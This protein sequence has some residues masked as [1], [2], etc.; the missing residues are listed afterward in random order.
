MKR[1]LV[2]TLLNAREET[3][4]EKGLLLDD[5]HFG[6]GDGDG[7]DR[8]R[9]GASVF[10]K[11][12]KSI[13]PG[14]PLHLQPVFELLVRDIHALE[15][16]RLGRVFQFRQQTGIAQDLPG[17]DPD[18][19]EIEGD[20]LPVDHQNLGGHVAEI[21]FQLEHGLTQAGGRLVLVTAAPELVAQPDTCPFAAR[22]EGQERQERA[23]LPAA[24]RANVAVPA[25]YR[26]RSKHVDLNGFAGRVVCQVHGTAMCRQTVHA[27][28]H[29]DTTV[30]HAKAAYF[31][32]AKF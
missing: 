2:A 30:K 28:T 20:G 18:R 32:S 24:W 31:I 3:Q 5:G 4:A 21:S 22:G 1:V 12:F 17:I 26:H 10:L 14:L 7:I 6:N 11:F 29:F 8:L 19:A 23:G 15:D 27:R 16:L 13:N 9:D 25:G